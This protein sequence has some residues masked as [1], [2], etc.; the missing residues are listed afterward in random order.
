MKLKIVFWGMLT[1]GLGMAAMLGACGDSS[2]ST[3]D[4]GDGGSTGSSSSSSTGSSSSS[5]MGSSSSSG[6]MAKDT[7]GDICG[8]DAECGAGMRCLVSDKDEAVLGGGPANGYCSKDCK[9]DSDC[10]GA[11]SVC[12][13][14]QT[15]NGVCM[16][17]CKIGEPALK[18]L[19]DPLDPDKCWGRDDVACTEINMLP[20]CLPL[21]GQDSQCDAGRKCDPALG[22]CV[23]M[24]TVGDP[25]GVSCDQMNDQCAGFCLGINGAPDPNFTMCSQG[26]VVGGDIQEDCGGLANG[27][28]AF[29]PQ[30]VGAGDFGFCTRSCK[31]QS[32]CLWQNKLWCVDIAGGQ[33]PFGFC[34][35]GGDPCT[36][37][38]NC[39]NSMGQPT[40]EKCQET[41]LGKFCLDP[42][43][44]LGDAAPTPMGCGGMGGMGGAGGCGGTGGGGMGGAGGN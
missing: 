17:G 31:V 14:D 26:C 21:C 18:Y 16:R 15:G 7:L 28:C 2:S 34:L 41:K 11:T 6:G 44:P 23:D 5:G 8:S 10:P 12:L 3:K 1:T 25:M 37:D 4:D 40:G 42:M 30:D 36:S 43:F 38:A 24:P 22:V 35:G 9:G 39:V 27:I 32:D 29:V 13:T 20:M 19:D 33:L